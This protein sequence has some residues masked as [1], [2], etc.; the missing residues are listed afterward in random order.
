M[1]ASRRCDQNGGSHGQETERWRRCEVRRASGHLWFLVAVCLLALASS[2]CGS[3][4][5]T[6]SPSSAP[7]PDP[8]VTAV[9]WTPVGQGTYGSTDAAE[10]RSEW[11]RITGTRLRV[12]CTISPWLYSDSYGYDIVLAP[13]STLHSEPDT[14]LAGTLSSA[15]D[16]F[17]RTVQVR[18]GVYCL[19]VKSENCAWKVRLLQFR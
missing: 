10:Y 3:N 16:K 1:P 15:D 8:A 14:F 5:T 11:F 12:K 6:K 13:K 18:P 9:G 7:S 17:Q 19:S 2:S 4:Q